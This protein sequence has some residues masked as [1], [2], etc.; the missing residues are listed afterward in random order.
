MSDQTENP[1]PSSQMKDSNS[2]D[3]E[4]SPERKQAISRISAEL[5]M[6]GPLQVYMH[7]AR[8]ICDQMDFIRDLDDLK[9][10]V[11]KLEGKRES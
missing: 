8:L 9:E 4:T 7:M 3:K 2:L 1:Q 10:R 5:S 11:K 6:M